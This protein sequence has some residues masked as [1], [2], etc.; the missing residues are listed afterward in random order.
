MSLPYFNT[1]KVNINIEI[2]NKKSIYCKIILMKVIKLTES[3]LSHII[4][5]VIQT[6]QDTEDT[7]KKESTNLIMTLR[8][9]AKGKISVDDLYELDDKIYDID[10]NNPLGQSIITFRF[11]DEK[12]FL[13]SIGLDEQDIWFYQALFGY[14]GYDFQDSYQIEEDFKEGYNVYYDLNE[15][16]KEQLKSIAGVILPEKEYDIENDEYRMELSRLLLDLFPTEIG[17]ILSD[18]EVEKEHEMNTVA[19]MSIKKEFD[20][21]LEN[22]GITFNYNQDEVSI[23]VAN[24]LMNSLKLGLWNE[25]AEESIIRI[26][27]ETIGSNPGGWYENSYE[28]QD[29][30]YFDGVSFNRE[31][32]RRF[33]DI[34]EKLEEENEDFYTVKDYVDFKNRITSKYK[35]KTWYEVPKNKNI[36]FYIESISFPNMSVNLNIKDK[37]NGLFKKLELSEENFTNF[38]YQYSL[39]GLENS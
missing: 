4:R 7:E 6:E 33:S 16:N 11:D 28:Y 10:V 24:L 31:V 3:E 5:R 14:N 26:I 17:W 13:E 8:N 2:P 27:Q 38:L 25:T 32:N 36:L 29:D 35:T 9:F 1:T 15:E 23:S 34:V 39:D 22:D 20:E 12:E 18:Y 30:D 37:E 21:P 19:K